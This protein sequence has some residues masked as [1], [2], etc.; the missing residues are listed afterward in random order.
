MVPIAI[1]GPVILPV[2]GRILWRRKGQTTLATSMRREH[3]ISSVTIE[4]SAIVSTGL[5]FTGCR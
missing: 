2:P 4:G 5:S 1:H 3:L